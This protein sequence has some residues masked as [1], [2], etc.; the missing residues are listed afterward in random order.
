MIGF[1]HRW[2]H[3]VC[4]Q[5]WKKGGLF[6][7]N[8]ILEMDKTCHL[9]MISIGYIPKCTS[10]LFRQPRGGCVNHMETELRTL[11]RQPRGGCVNHMETEL[12]YIT[13][14]IMGYV[15]LT[16]HPHGINDSTGYKSL[17]EQHPATARNKN[18]NQN[19]DSRV[20][21]NTPIVSSWPGLQG[22]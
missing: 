15:T 22:G 8:V 11:F 1:S 19:L 4:D 10:T 6:T 20:V 21:S 17:L 7:Q 16:I 5:I 13:D 2:S 18:L 3:I 14:C 12:R 9:A